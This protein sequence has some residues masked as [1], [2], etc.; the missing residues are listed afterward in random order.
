MSAAQFLMTNTQDSWEVLC[1]VLHTQL[2]WET[3]RLHV[4]LLD[5][6]SEEQPEI[7]RP[8]WACTGCSVQAD[9]LET[10]SQ[11]LWLPTE[12]HSLHPPQAGDES[13]GRFSSLEAGD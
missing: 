1:I 8:L 12:G 10:Q 4:W 11:G 9:R 2:M 6:C 13:S 7:S 3:L 5:T